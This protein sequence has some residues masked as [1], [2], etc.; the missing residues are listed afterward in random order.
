H[1]RPLK[2]KP[3]N[4]IALSGP[5]LEKVIR[6]CWDRHPPLGAYVELLA[7]TASRLHE[8]PSLSPGALH[9]PP[10]KRG[11]PRAF[12]VTRR[13][14]YLMGQPRAFSR[15]IWLEVV[16]DLGLPGLKPHHLR[17]SA[18]TIAGSHR[19]ASLVDL[20]ALGGWKSPQMAARYLHPGSR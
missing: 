11:N 7:L 10:Q 8:S 3:A 1:I 19:D 14:R 15:P 4:P 12:R 20:M 16:R 13:L 2:E 5:A 6:A 9:Y 17:H 18:L